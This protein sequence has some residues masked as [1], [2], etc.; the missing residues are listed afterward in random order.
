MYRMK[1]ELLIDGP[2][3]TR[4][5]LITFRNPEKSGIKMDGSLA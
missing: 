2:S 4:G 3:S 5:E 1:S